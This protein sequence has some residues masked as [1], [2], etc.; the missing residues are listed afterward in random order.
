LGSECRQEHSTPD[1]KSL[2]KRTCRKPN[3]SRTPE[4]KIP[5]ESEA[6]GWHQDNILVPTTGSIYHAKSLTLKHFQIP[7]E[8]ILP[9][10]IP[11]RMQ[12]LAA[13]AASLPFIAASSDLRLPAATPPLPVAAKTQLQG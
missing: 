1:A 4:A 8:Q 10:N 12:L 3:A 2:P 11:K 13:S 7:A 5:A 6:S 9:K